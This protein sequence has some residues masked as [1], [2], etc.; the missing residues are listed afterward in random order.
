MHNSTTPL[1]DMDTTLERLKGDREFLLTLFTVYLEDL[2]TKVATLCKAA[3][4]K[5]LD[6]VLRTAHSL[7]GA[8]ATIGALA[9]REAAQ[10]IELASRNGDLQTALNAIPSLKILLTKLEERLNMELGNG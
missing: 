3:D 8:S 5:S 9:V 10:E 2:P 1:L 7:K 4:D 6:D